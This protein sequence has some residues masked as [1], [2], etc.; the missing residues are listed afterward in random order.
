MGWVG[1]GGCSSDGKGA[2]SRKWLMAAMSINLSRRNDGERGSFL[3]ISSGCF[4]RLE[5]YFRTVRIQTDGCAVRVELGCGIKQ[6]VNTMAK[7]DDP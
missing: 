4:L 1:V 7:L 5:P 3:S 6:L 2:V